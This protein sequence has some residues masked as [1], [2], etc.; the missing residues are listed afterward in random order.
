MY[1]SLTAESENKSMPTPVMLNY[2]SEG[3]CD[4]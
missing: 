3:F 4:R 1:V 2:D